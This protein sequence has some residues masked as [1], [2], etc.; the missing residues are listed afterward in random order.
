MDTDIRNPKND[1]RNSL[2]THSVD[3]FGHSTSLGSALSGLPNS[4]LR[5]AA[6]PRDAQ[7]APRRRMAG[8]SQ[9]SLLRV[10]VLRALAAAAAAVHRIAA[11]NVL[12]LLHVPSEAGSAVIFVEEISL[13]R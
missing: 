4:F 10:A 3:R 1:C 12:S 5:S 13:R 7:A 9:Y 2:N 11:H 8:A 6:G